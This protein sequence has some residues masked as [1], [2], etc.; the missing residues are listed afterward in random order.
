[1][2]QDARMEWSAAAVA[3]KNKVARVETMLDGKFS[4]CARHHY[5]RDRDDPVG[6]LN[7]AVAA[8]VIEGRRDALCN[9]VLRRSNIEFHLTTK[10]ISG[11][12]TPEHQLRVGD[13]G[14]GATAAV[15]HRTG[16]GA[17]ALRT[18]AK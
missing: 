9:G 8:R 6:H 3:E 5:C 11:I 1:M 10:K 13:C 2:R 17:R 16:H 18:D 15:T 7:H 4:D 14:L 12:E